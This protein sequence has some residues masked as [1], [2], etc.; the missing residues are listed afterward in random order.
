[1]TGLRVDHVTWAETDL[2]ALRSRMDGVGLPS[3]YGG[4]HSNGVT[5]MAVVAFPDG[6]YV[7]LLAPRE[8]N[9]RSPVWE[10]AVRAEAGPAAW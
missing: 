4:P 7:E 5:H 2:D 1:M 3:A 6:S 9:R 10:R 8:P